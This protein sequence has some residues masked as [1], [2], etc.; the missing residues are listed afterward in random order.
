MQVVN[1]TDVDSKSFAAMWQLAV[2]LL[3]LI[4]QHCDVLCLFT[5]QQYKFTVSKGDEASLTNQRRE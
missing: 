5:Q 2:E 3:L 1:T 4:Q